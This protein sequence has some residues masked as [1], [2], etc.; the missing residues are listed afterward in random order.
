MEKKS[1][2]LVDYSHNKS[3]Q[4]IFDAPPIFAVAKA[5][6]ASNA[7]ELG[8][9]AQT[10]RICSMS[11]GSLYWYSFRLETSVF[12]HSARL[13]DFSLFAAEK[14]YEKPC[15]N[16]FSDGNLADFVFRKLIFW[17]TG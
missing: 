10:G 2:P 15:R 7:A 14:L 13:S 9:Q 8:F 17:R 12:R 3:L 11:L 4:R 5:G 16:C 1:A 6:V